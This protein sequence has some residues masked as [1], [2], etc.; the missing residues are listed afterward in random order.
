M[1]VGR[2]APSPTGLLHLGH[3]R[4]FHAAWRRA[5]EAGGELR[6]RIEDLD[7]GRCKP[8]FERAC[9]EDFAWMGIDW[10]G[11]VVRQSERM[12]RYRSAW[13][14]LVEAGVVFPCRRS[15]RDVRMAAGA[16]HE[17]GGEAVY[18]LAWRGRD[19]GGRGRAGRRELAF[20][21][22]VGEGGDLRGRAGRAAAFRGGVWTSGISWCW[23]R[24][25]GPAYEL[26]VVVDD[27]DMGVTEVVRGRDLLLSTARQLLVYEALGEA[28]PAFAHTPLVRDA[29]GRRL[30]K[31]DGDMGLRRLREAGKSFEAALRLAG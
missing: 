11:P 21:G 18:P 30:A 3:A 16:P 1:Y 8:E 20:P 23:R 6:L 31:R 28:A 22:A 27:A 9:L 10:D 4:T 19:A 15:R 14:R 12:E 24:G 17:E 2:L 13:R 25:G 29:Q 7:R 5:R 26:A